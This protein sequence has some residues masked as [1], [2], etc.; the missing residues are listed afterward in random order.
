MAILAA[1]LAFGSR[2]AG[3]ILTTALGWASTLLFGRVPA[4]RQPFLLGITFGSVIWLVLL[5]GVLFPDLGTFLLVL[6]PPQDFVPEWVIRLAMLIGALTVPAVVGILVALLRPADERTPR[7]IA[8]SIAR[9]YPLT[10]LLAVLLLFLAGLAIWRKGTSLARGWTDAHVPIVVTAGAYDQ[11]AADLDAAVTAAGLEVEPKPAPATMSAPAKWLARVAGQSSAVLVPDRMIQLDG[12]DL[13]ILIYPMDL[14]IAGKPRLVARARAAMASRLT[15][16]AAH[17]TISAEA[18]AIE[19]RLTGL[20]R[21]PADQPDARPRY[22]ERVEATLTSIDEELASVDI[23]YEE[24]EVLYRQRLQVERDLRA[25]AMAEETVLGA[26][27]VPEGGPAAA[28]DRVGRW[29]RAGAGAMIE[30]AGDERTV[31]A[32]DKAA[33]PEWRWAARAASVAAGAA[34]EVLREDEARDVEAGEPLAVEEP[35][36]VRRP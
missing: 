24:W 33:G 6:V 26:D 27:A 18:Q 34:R 36:S 35:E 13:D 16:T 21:R 14:L 31:E 32:L 19:D 1:L 3:K 23:Q 7:V 8:E 28:L 4:D 25:G 11:V 17:L 22:D 2:F 9:G 29:L 30:A 10:V 12:K 5:G 15:T 20:I